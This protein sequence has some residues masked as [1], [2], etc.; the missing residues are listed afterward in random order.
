MV[1]STAMEYTDGLMGQ[2]IKENTNIIIIMGK[3]ITGRQM[4]MNIGECTRM[5]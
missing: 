3:D 2:Y 5:A 1:S 4:P